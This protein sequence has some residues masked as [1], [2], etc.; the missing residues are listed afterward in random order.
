MKILGK[1]K[2]ISPYRDKKLN[3]LKKMIEQK[4]NS[5]I[6]KENKK[7]LIFTAFEDTA[8]YLYENVHQWI[9]ENYHLHSALVTG[10]EN[11]KTTL[12]LKKANFNNVLTNFSPL[13]KEREK[14]MPEMDEE[15][16][17]LIATDCISEGQN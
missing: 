5:P 9:F 8:K 12:K 11:P 1:T 14:V 10:S 17:I 3:R 4:I 7:V 16:D 2:E 6:N 13:S 15:I